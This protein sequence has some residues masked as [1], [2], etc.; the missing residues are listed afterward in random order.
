MA[1]K[2]AQPEPPVETQQSSELEKLTETLSQPIPDSSKAIN[3]ALEGLAAN[4]ET[5]EALQEFEEIVESVKQRGSP[6]LADRIERVL[7]KMASGVLKDVERLANAL[8]RVSH[9]RTAMIAQRDAILVHLQTEAAKPP[10]SHGELY[11]RTDA[12]EEDAKK[13][14][15]AE[16]FTLL[17]ASLK[18][19]L[20]GVQ[21]NLN[22]ANSNKI[23]RHSS[24]V[25]RKFPH[26]KK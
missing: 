2:P 7:G 26:L 23:W 15:V 20:M 6:K 5:A 25:F 8:E 10:V 4:T 12:L 18:P 21:G 3:N 19:V 22:L 9:E 13:R 16:K 14:I 1:K 11:A 17:W 24:S